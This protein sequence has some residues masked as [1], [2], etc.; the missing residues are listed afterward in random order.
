MYIKWPKTN[1]KYITMTNIE[2]FLTISKIFQKYGKTVIFCYFGQIAKI[3]LK[4]NK[5][6]TFIKAELKI[7]MSKQLLTNK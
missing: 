2:I 4:I 3:F 7:R 5:N 6:D 1:S